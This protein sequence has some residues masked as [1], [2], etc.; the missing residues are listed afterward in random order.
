[1]PSIEES[2]E[3]SV[4]KAIKPLIEDLDMLRSQIVS[5]F[6]PSVKAKEAAGMMSLGVSKI[7]EL[8]KRPDFYPAVWIDDPDGRTGRV[9]F[10]PV[11]IIR[12]LHEHQNKRKNPDSVAI[13]Q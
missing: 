4:S 9:V 10:L 1:M 5:P 6:P 7:Y 8:A 3:L 13:R 12:W 11:E 2:L